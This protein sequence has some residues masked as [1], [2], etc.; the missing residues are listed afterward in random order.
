M[1]GYGGWDGDWT[2]DT[3]HA[4]QVEPGPYWTDPTEYQKPAGAGTGR[5]VAVVVLSMVVVVLAGLLVF[6]V[7]DRN[8]DETGGTGQVA[9][10][11]GSAN[12]ADGQSGIAPQQ[13]APQQQM[14]PQQQA[15]QYG[16]P[17]PE[18]A[19]ADPGAGGTSGGSVNAPDSGVYTGYLS[20]RGTTSGRQD[21][22]YTVEMTF[23]SGGSSV[24]YPSLG[25]SGTLSPQGDSGDARVYSERISS[26][27]CDPS[28]TWTIKRQSSSSIQ[29]EYRPTSGRY[30]VV[31]ELSR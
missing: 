10:A 17:R 18:V 5:T 16:S 19:P 25:C 14:A 4:P 26:G 27:N 11:S 28:G 13:Q 2:D 20:Q 15:P 9:F 21:R 3:R 8:R 24:R 29:A 30:V 22:D 6:L 23:S 31:G 7:V 1:G 12:P